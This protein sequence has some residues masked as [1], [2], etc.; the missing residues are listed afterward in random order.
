MKIHTVQSI[1]KIALGVAIAF[2]SALFAVTSSTHRPIVHELIEWIGVLLILLC[3][4]G[5]TWASLYIGGRKIEELVR[6]GP[7]SICRNPLYLFSI[8]GAAGIGAQSGSYTLAITCAIIAYIIFYAVVL[9]EERVL[10]KRYGTEYGEYTDQVPRF[11]PRPWLW[12]DESTLTIRPKRVMMT[13]ADALLFLLA[14]P[15]AEG[16]EYLQ[17]SGA[18]PIL[19]RLP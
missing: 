16:I 5:R 7:F 6:I 10:H 3:I 15:L 1:R 8:I 11:I 13:F 12:W 17:N 9:Q 2:G 19:F 18:L 14:I 4:L